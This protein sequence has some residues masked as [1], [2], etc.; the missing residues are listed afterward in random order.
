MSKKPVDNEATVRRKVEA[1]A[2][3]LL[4]EHNMDSLR[5]L[6]RNA[7]GVEYRGNDRAKLAVKLAM[8]SVT[9]QKQMGEGEAGAPSVSP[10]AQASAGNGATKPSKKDERMATEV[11]TRVRQSWDEVERLTEE[12]KT[13]L[14]EFRLQI[15]SAK[16]AIAETLADSDL[17][18]TKRLSKVEGYWRTMSR[19]EQKR[20]EV[21]QEYK[22]LISAARQ[23]VKHEMDHVRQLPLFAG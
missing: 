17:S 23:S 8:Y 10:P 2:S 7:F 19:T 18:E 3:T 22:K 1:C 15:T 16:T 9:G 12:R 13:K 5:Q 14:S 11:L 6:H 20:A 21:S 4:Q